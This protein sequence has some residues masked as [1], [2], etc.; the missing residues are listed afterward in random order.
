[1]VL[2][3]G[4]RKLALTAHVTTS[5]GWLGAVVTFLA[6]ALAGLT[7]EDDQ[8]VRAVYLSMEVIGRYVLLPLAVVSVLSGLVQSLGTTWGLF[9]HYW[10]I[11]K[12]FMTVL[13]TLFLLAYLPTLGYLGDAASSGDVS[14]VLPRPSPVLHAG[15]A[16]VVLLVA[17]VLSVYKPRGM[18]AYG[19]RKQRVRRRR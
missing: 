3:P 4:P 15:A 12:L 2:T 1:M 13:A 19:Q 6:L 10:V 8:T 17:A 18:T 5:V 16:L 14:G 7:N 9:Q 11:I